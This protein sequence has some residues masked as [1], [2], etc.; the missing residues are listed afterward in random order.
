MKKKHSKI[1]IISECFYPEEFKINDIAFNWAKQGCDI[2]VLTLNPTYPR[3]KIFPG[4]RN[5]FFTKEHINGLNI[6]RV[7]AVIGYKESKFKKI[8]KYL[9]FMILGVIFALFIGKRYQHVF[10]F[11]LGALSDMLP[12]VIIRK[13]YK[14]PLTLWVQDLWP[15][16][17]YAYGF[18]KTKFL[19][20][21]LTKFVKFIFNNV[22]NIAISSKGFESNLLNYIQSD[23]KIHYY[24]NWAD[25]L[26]NELEPIVLNDDKRVQFT[27]AGNVGKVQNLENIINAYSLLP[28]SYLQKSQLNIIGDG[29]NLNYLK[30]ITRKNVPI[31]FHGGVQRD[32]ISKYYKASDFLIISLIN[33]PLFSS[34]VP[35]KLQTYISAKKPILAIINGETKEIVRS[36]CLGLY[37]EPDNIHAILRLFQDCIKMPRDDHKNFLNNNDSLLNDLFNKKRIIRGLKDLVVNHD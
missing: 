20:F 5:R 3:G 25:D 11:N 31:I 9:N 37:S 16:S 15:D 29:S 24:P 4:Y 34:T 13:V 32:I 27:F 18:K 17:V 30:S 26:N 8:L 12:A 2:D 28:K 19:S 36:N 14:R 7:R 35:A 10:G 1:L 21:I 22:D 6:Y 23:K 33:K